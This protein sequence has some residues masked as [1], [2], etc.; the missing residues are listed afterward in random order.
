MGALIWL[1]W[2]QDF[3]AQ[4]DPEPLLTFL[5]ATGYWIV[6]EFR[7]SEEVLEKKS[8]ANDIALSRELIEFHQNE[9][10]ELREIDLFQ[11][12]NSRIY[13]NIGR[14]IDGFRSGRIFFQDKNLNQRM[15]KLI[16]SLEILYAHI[17]QNTSPDLIG[18]VMM[19]AYKPNE[20][21]SQEEY[22]RRM[23]LAGEANKLVEVAS[24][25]FDSLISKIKTSVPEAYDEKF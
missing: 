9:F 23:L 6:T 10:R 4:I 21:V 19:T 18:N 13:S 25:S 2:P 7:S 16:D 17:C 22:D 1:L 14:T 11:Y 8:T 12:V 24:K 3:L 5:V 15:K 20:N